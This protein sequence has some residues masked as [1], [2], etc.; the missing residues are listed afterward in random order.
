[1]PVHDTGIDETN[2]DATG[3]VTISPTT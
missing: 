3:T 2:Y 1:L